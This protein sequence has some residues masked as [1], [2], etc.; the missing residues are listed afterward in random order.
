MP[1]RTGC[2]AAVAVSRATAF[3]PA[4]ASTA[5]IAIASAWSE[6][7]RQHWLAPAIN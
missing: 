5:R 2:N 4:V 7:K 6:A 1:Y 3:T